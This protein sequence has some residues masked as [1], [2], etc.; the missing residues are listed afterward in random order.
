MFL[1]TE[2]NEESRLNVFFLR[3]NVSLKSQ[4]ESP[5][6]QAIVDPVDLRQFA[7]S[8]KKFNADLDDSLNSLASQLSA[9]STT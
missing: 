9:L 5:M 1:D 3:R 4:E 6:A 8:L 2:Y 7:Q